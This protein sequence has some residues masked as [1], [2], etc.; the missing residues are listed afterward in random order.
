[1]KTSSMIFSF[2]VLLASQVSLAK[3][4]LVSAEEAKNMKAAIGLYK[5]GCS[6]YDADDVQTRIDNSPEVYLD[7][8]GAQPVLV[9]VKYTNKRDQRS[10]ISVTTDA[11]YTTLT[12]IR[13]EADVLT[14][15]NRGTIIKPRIVQEF[16]KK[17]DFRCSGF[18]L[19]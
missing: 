5:Y 1:M 17:Q 3:P 10:R 4:V 7:T 11:S 8:S 19:K 14:P 16:V 18:S 12:G 9:F 15:V 2:L 13:F 6:N